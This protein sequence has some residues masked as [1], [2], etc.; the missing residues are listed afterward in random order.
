MSKKVD[1]LYLSQDDVVECGGADMSMVMERIEHFFTLHATGQTITPD[2]TA[3][4]WGDAASEM[5]TGRINAMPGYVG[6][7]VDTAGIKWIGSKPKN[8]E[9]YGLPRASALTIINDPETGFPLAVMDGTVISAMRT[10]A[11]TGVATKYLARKNSRTAVFIGAG[12]QNHTQMLAVVTALPSI[13]EIRICDLS[14]QR[15]DAFVEKETKNFPSISFK[16]FSSAEDAVRG[17]DVV[18]TATTTQNPIVRSEW[19]EPGVTMVN[20]GN[21]EYDFGAVLKADKVVLDNWDA[22]IHRGIQ[23]VAIMNSEGKFEREK[24]YAE[25]GEI[26]SGKKPGRESDGETTYFCGVGMGAEDVAVARKVYERALEK[27]A[28]T[29]LTLWNEPRWV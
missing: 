20:V 16:G 15:V 26:T 7:D 5:I 25:L 18:V 27:N 4:R 6:G 17:A 23:T 19:I 3:L 1:F 11:V 22:V 8:P 2:K 21:Y 14:Q 10:G 29:R 9:K 28:G 24:L 12:T 13:E